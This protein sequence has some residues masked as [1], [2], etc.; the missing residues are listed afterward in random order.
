MDSFEARL[1]FISVIKNLQKTL[2]VSKRLDNDPVQFYLNHYEQHYEDF[3][4][5]LFDTAAK[6]DSLDRL[7]VVIYYSK[8]VQVLHGEQTELNARVLNQLL[9]PSI[10]SMLLLALPSQ[11]WKALTNLDAC[12]DIF[13]K[14][15]SLMGGIVELKK[16][17]MDS[18]LPLDKLQW[19]T[20]SEHPSIHYH[21]SFQRAAT[22]L[23]DRCAKQQHMFQQFK[24]FGLCPVT[25]SRPQPST[26][27]IIH[28]M[29]SDREKHKRLKEN[30]WVLPRPHASILNEFEFRTLWE[31]TPQEG[32]TKGDY[33]NMSDMNRI[34]HASYSVK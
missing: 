16:P 15:N 3:H 20:P 23:Q 9:L 5:C 29:E 22:L 12:I 25:L 27:T 32:L 26:Q 8:I 4:Q 13:Q 17:T 21:E 1:Q 34:A 18:H 19:Y 30:I 7:N 33:R 11:D 14:C 24:L 31:S 28:R 2:G 6:M 10:D